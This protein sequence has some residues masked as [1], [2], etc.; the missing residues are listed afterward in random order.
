MIIYNITTQVSW[1]V[2]D[3]WKRWFTDEYLPS[4]LGTGLFTHYQLVRLMEVNEEEG[5][6]YA[7]QLYSKDS[8]TFEAFRNNYLPDLQ[9]KERTEWGDNTFSFG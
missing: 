2:H 4:L 6:T 9:E 5:A 1:A 8:E 7:V 3:G